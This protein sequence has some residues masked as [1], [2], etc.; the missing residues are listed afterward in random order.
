MDFSQMYNSFFFTLYIDSCSRIIVAVGLGFFS[1]LS[2]EE[3][4][5]HLF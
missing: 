1:F 5:I 2:Y 3:K 4:G